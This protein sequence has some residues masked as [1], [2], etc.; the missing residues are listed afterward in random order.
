MSPRTKQNLENAMKCDALESATYSRF[1]AH[2]RMDSE[3]ELARVFQDSADC[4]RTEHFAREAAL[5]GLVEDSPENLRNALDAET[6]E[7]G[8]YRQFALEAADD[9]DLSVAA[10]FDNICRQK[11]GRCTRLEALLADM[12]FHSHIRTVGA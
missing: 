2:A 9:G 3:W 1:A 5:E 8:M 12:G 10:E 11:A 7:F 4:D 6:K